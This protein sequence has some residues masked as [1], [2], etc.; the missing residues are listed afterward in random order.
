MSITF[1]AALAFFLLV[2]AIFSI[3]DLIR[4]NRIRGISGLVAVLIVIGTLNLATGFPFP[5][6]G[7]IAFGAGYSTTTAVVTMFVGIVLGMLGHY[8]WQRPEQFSVIELLRPLV[9][10]P[11]VLL[12]LIGSLDGTDV[13]PLQLISL[14]LLA[15]QNGFFWPKVLSDADPATN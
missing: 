10:S 6:D 1:I 5:S 14:V 4:G 3:V 8:I 2:S 13:Q 9:A 12:P 11:I 7:A 15:F